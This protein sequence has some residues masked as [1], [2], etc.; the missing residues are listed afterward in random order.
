MDRPVIQ[1]DQGL[2]EY[3]IPSLHYGGQSHDPSG[4]D[5]NYH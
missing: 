3:N 5:Q 2:F 4:P 1:V